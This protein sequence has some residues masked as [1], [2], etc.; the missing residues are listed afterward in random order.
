MPIYEAATVDEAVEI[1]L[2]ELGLA[3]E[4]VAIEILDEGKKDFS[5]WEKEMPNFQSNR[6]SAKLSLKR[7]KKP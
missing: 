2:N 5:E 3:K 1:G 6:I 7:S 4:Q